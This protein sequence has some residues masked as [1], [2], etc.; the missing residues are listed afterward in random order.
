[1]RL[2]EDP[3]KAPNEIL[4]DGIFLNIVISILGARELNDKGVR[5]AILFRV[6]TKGNS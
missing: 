1:L 4:M 6:A 2:L 5:N 3:V